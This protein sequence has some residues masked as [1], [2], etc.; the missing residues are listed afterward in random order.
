RVHAEAQALDAAPGRQL[1]GGGRRDVEGEDAVAAPVRDEDAV[2]APKVGGQ[3]RGLA[4]VDGARV[5]RRVRAPRDRRDLLRV[6]ALE[7]RE[8]RLQRLDVD[9]RQLE[10][11]RALVGVADVGEGGAIG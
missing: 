3:L 8:E 9:G 2:D 7:G 5:E 6:Q 10:G 11:L 1:V 4:R